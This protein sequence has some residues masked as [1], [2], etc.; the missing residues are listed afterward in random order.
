MTNRQAKN[1]PKKISLIEMINTYSS[2]SQ[3]CVDFFFES[4]FPEGFYCEKCGCT[5]YYFIKRGNV[6]QCQHCGHQHYLLADTIFQDCKLPLFKIILGL[7][8]VFTSNKGISAVELANHLDVNRKTAQLFNRKCRV[9]MSQSNSNKILSSKFYEADVAYIGAK[10][11]EEHHQGTAT[12]KQAFLVMLSTDKE[13]KY[14]SY[15]KLHLLK[16][17]T[18]ELI[19][20]FVSKSMKLGKE[21]ILNTDGKTTFNILSDKITLKS[22]KIIYTEANHRLY[23]LNVIIGNFKTHIEGIYHGISKR[24]LPLF[25]NEQQWRFNH[26]YS[27]KSIM[28]NV[29]NYLYHSS[30]FT[31]RQIKTVLDLSLPHFSNS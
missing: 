12:E 22:E 30:P 1:K 16:N 28:K 26:R 21:R 3:A 4:K 6:F 17:D 25:L 27:G 10:S 24:L 23:W 8:L 7:Y 5:H 18:S 15:I 2:N 13:N 9:L 20:R 11:K 29:K 19:N 14:P 31:A